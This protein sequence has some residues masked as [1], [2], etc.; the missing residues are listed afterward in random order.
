M[1]TVRH[2]MTPTV[3]TIHPDKLVCEVEGIFVAHKISG[4]PLGSD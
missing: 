4:A 3:V 1:R 2:I